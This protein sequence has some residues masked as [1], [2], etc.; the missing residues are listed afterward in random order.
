MVQHVLLGDLAPL[1]FVAALTGPLLRPVLALPVIGKLRVL[2]H[3]LVAL[4][5]WAVNL[6]IWHLP[7]LYEA[8]LRHDSVHALEHVCFFTGGALM[9]APVVEVLPGPA[10]FGTGTKLGYIVVVRLDR[11]RARQRLPLVGQGLLPLL[12]DRRGRP[13]RFAAPRPGL[14]RRR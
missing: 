10:W 7:A 13:R 1:A 6:Y 11:D 4:P 12:R 2:A 3:P 9:W 14:G 5:I 8:A